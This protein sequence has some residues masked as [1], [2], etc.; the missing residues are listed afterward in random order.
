MVNVVVVVFVVV[1]LDVVV[2]AVVVVA[3]LSPLPFLSGSQSWPWPFVRTV[4]HSL[5]THRWLYKMRA[6]IHI[7]LVHTYNYLRTQ[8]VILRTQFVHSLLTLLQFA[9][10]H[11]TTYCTVYCTVYYR[12]FYSVHHTVCYKV[13]Y[14]VY[15]TVYCT[16]YYTVYYTVY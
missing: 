9:K 12:V 13:C 10:V 16:V 7:L 11:C 4:R 8:I 1:V 3:V 2:F 5:Y 15:Y 6:Q 14:T